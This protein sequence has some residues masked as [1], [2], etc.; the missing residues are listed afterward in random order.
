MPADAPLLFLIGETASGKK[1]IAR[2]VA[3]ELPIELLAM[4]SMKVYRGMDLGT[5]KLEA[6]RFALTDLVEPSERFSTGAWVRAAVHE[7]A[8]IRARGRLPLF[9]GGTGLYLRAI[10]RGIFDVPS[11]GEAARARARARIAGGGPGA[12][13]AELA[14]ID[15]G[16]AARL[17]GNDERRA[18][19][20]LEVFE[21]T[22]SPLSLLQRERTRRPIEGRP[23]LVGL[24][25]PRPALATRIEQRVDLML[26]SG[27]IE[28]V[29]RLE[30]KGGIGE[31]AGSAIGYRQ[32]AAHLRGERSL[33]ECRREILS[34]TRTFV[35]RQRNWFKQ[36]P[37]TVWIDADGGTEAVARR[38]AQAFRDAI[39]SALGSDPRSG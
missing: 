27:W 15:P 34:A 3:A 28:E 7:V 18:V 30:A 4:D 25:W 37:E 16:T 9:V 39:G 13:H 2:T 24:R 11:I 22:G 17:H 36:F 31:V 38:A 21:E 12:A 29:R 10:V 19:R 6:A 20:A 14:R 1:R 35:R 32:I 33:G 26:V 8:A 5:D 23:I